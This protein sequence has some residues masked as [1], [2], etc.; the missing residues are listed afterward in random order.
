MPLP[1]WN[2]PRWGGSQGVSLNYT[3]MQQQIGS[4]QNAINLQNAALPTTMPTAPAAAP[5]KTTLAGMMAN[6]PAFRDMMNKYLASS[7]PGLPNA[8]NTWGGGGF[9]G[10]TDGV[11]MM[12]G[13]AYR[14]N[15]PNAMYHEPW[16]W[17]DSF[18][19]QRS[20]GG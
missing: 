19:N 1:A 11:A 9:G 17:S 7:T 16:F 14:K 15:D 5:A 4:P 12:A 3:P 10:D 8:S 2:I 20:G 6:N 18:S 13:P